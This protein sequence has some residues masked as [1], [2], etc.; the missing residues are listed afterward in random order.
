[1][2]GTELP[3]SVDALQE[4]VLQQQSTIEQQAELVSFL[5]EWNRLLRSQKFGARSEKFAPEQG[6]SVLKTRRPAPKS[7][8]RP[9]GRVNHAASRHA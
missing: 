1:M 5:R 3:S 7:K 4:I 6:L 2:A 9:G 8:S